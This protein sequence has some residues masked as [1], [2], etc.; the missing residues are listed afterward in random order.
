VKLGGPLKEKRLYITVTLGPFESKVAYL[1]ITVAVGPLWKQGT[2]HITV[3]IGGP[4]ES[5]VSLLTHYTCYCGPLWKRRTYTLQL[6]LWSPWKQSTY[7][8]QLLLSFLPSRGPA[9]TVV[10]RGPFESRVTYWHIVVWGPLGRQ[11][12][13]LR[14]GSENTI[15]ADNTF[16]TKNEEYL[17]AKYLDGGP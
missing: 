11:T 4:F 1:Y 8:T 14:C 17:R 10:V 16:F 12:T 9:H 13:E 6:L 5:V 3:D 2:L 7:T 15:R